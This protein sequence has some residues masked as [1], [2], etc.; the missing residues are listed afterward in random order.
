M[1]Y[2]FTEKKSFV[3]NLTEITEYTNQLGINGTTKE[4]ISN[5]FTT[6]RKNKRIYT[7]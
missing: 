5:I 4:T 6:L 1:F 7:S 3:E 2:C